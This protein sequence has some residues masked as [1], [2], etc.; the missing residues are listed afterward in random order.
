M[1]KIDYHKQICYD[2]DTNSYTMFNG[3][4]SDYR[5]DFFG[6]HFPKFDPDIS[7]TLSGKQRKKL[8]PLSI[9]YSNI[10]KLKNYSDYFPITRKFEGYG[11]FPHPLSV[12][13]SNIPTWEVKPRNRAGLINQLQKFSSSDEY[14]KIMNK[15][16]D[17]KGLSYLTRDLT[18]FDTVKNDGLILIDTINKTFDE[19]KEQYKNQLNTFDK[20]PA[21]KALK[22]FKK[23]LEENSEKNIVNGKE[24]KNY[25][26]D[27]KKQYDAV[28]SCIKSSK[29]IKNEKIM[30]PKIKENVN[31]NVRYENKK[32]EN[33]IN[34]MFKSNDCTLGKKMN[35]PF[36]IFSYEEEKINLELKKKEKEEEEKRKQEEEKKKQEEEK[37]KQEE[38][39]KKSEEEKKKSEEEKKKS[40]EEQKKLENEKNEENQKL[41]DITLD[42]KE[43]LDLNEKKE[44]TLDDKLK[45]GDLS[46]VSYQSENEKKYE[47][48]NK[49]NVKSFN[50]IEKLLDKEKRFLKGYQINHKI[51]NEFPKFNWPKLITN[52]ELYDN[53]IKNLEKVNP[54]AFQMEKEKMELD[55]KQ[56]KRKRHQNKLNYNIIL[57]QSQKQEKLELEKSKRELEEGTYK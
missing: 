16:N 36:G 37:K 14:L 4:K 54:I 27:I 10:P 24:L 7:G 53:D 49:S 2:Y 6:R 18:E 40:E 25:G 41:N 48:D 31:T 11:Q 38:E 43:S 8:T 33:Y 5:C 9:D 52:G 3:E 39:K 28:Y 44:E 20:L 19:Y 34:D 30:L 47:N 26:E 50:K 17:N 57:R 46:F 29:G 15:S 56:L 32:N 45:K 42:T 51:E 12:P 21:V 1:N 55:L 13:F 35:K 22:N 23:V